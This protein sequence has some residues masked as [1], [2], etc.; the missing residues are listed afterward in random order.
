[1][2]DTLPCQPKNHPT[3]RINS[4]RKTNLSTSW[5]EYTRTENTAFPD[6]LS[7]KSVKLTRSLKESGLKY[8]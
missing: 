2:A 7:V 1:M 4:S 3:R 6:F 5:D 8:T